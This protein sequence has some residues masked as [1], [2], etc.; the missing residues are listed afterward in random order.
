MLLCLN[1]YS[2]FNCGAHWYAETTINDYSNKDPAFL[3]VFV[4]GQVFELSEK[5][6]QKDWR[7]ERNNESNA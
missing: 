5:V 7:L 3:S 2:D 1:F 6:K 4:C